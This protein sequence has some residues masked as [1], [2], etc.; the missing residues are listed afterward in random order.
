MCRYLQHFSNIKYYLQRKRLVTIRCL[1]L[2]EIADTNTYSV[3]QLLLCKSSL[4]SIFFNRLSYNFILFRMFL[5][6]SL[7]SCF[8]PLQF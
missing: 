2:G 5:T 1:D 8:L 6:H 3:R 4:F 7:I